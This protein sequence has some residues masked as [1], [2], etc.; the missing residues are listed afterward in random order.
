MY[1]HLEI[2]K[3]NK[4]NLK[5]MRQEKFIIYQHQINPK[6]KIGNKIKLYYQILKILMI[7]EIEKNKIS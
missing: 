3:N 7:N 5:I 4:E 2:F 6:V 1:L